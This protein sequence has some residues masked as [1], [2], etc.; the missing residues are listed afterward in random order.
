MKREKL[1]VG[2]PAL[3][4]EW[5]YKKNGDLRPEQFSIG[6]HKKIWWRCEYGHS[7]QSF[8]YS[9]ESCGCPVCA[10]KTVVVGFNDLQTLNPDLAKEWDY[11]KNG[12]L[13]PKDFTAGSNKKVWWK[14]KLGHSWET[15]IAHRFLNGSNCPY[16]TGRIVWQGYNDIVTTHPDIADQWDYEK[17]G[18]LRPE[19][20][21]IGSNKKIWW[22]CKYGHSWQVMICKRKSRGCPVCAGKVVVKGIN[23]LLTLNP[24]LAKE[25]D[26]IKNGNW[27]PDSVTI[28]SNSKAWWLCN[29]GH[30]WDATI[31]DRSYGNGCPYCAGK[32]V[33]VGE[34]DLKTLRPDLCKEWDYEKNFPLRPE[35]VMSCTGQYIWWI[36]EHGHSWKAKLAARNNG[37]R[38]PYCYGK[39]PVRT[40][41]VK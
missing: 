15:I 22:E 2:Y 28:Y 4:Q 12:K 13:Q 11:E 7:W 25:W 16:C 26:P 6:S 39:T 1:T 40:R 21:S 32:R 9:R 3:L 33:I 34:T 31:S 14:C 30:S 19:Q 20:F 18:N 5:D 38:C 41:L 36:C 8:L 35:D 17:N 24:D 27:R 29:K 10:G 37:T 23:D